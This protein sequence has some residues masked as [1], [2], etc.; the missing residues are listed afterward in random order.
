MLGEKID[1]TLKIENREISLKLNMKSLKNLGEL[2]RRNPFKY[3][4]DF[5][6]EKDEDN[7]NKMLVNILL[8]FTDANLTVEDL[9]KILDQNKEMDYL[10]SML[11]INEIMCEIEEDKKGNSKNEID[12]EEE[13]E[14]K[15]YKNWC[16]T[17]N[18]YYYIATVQF[19]MS[20]EEFL[21]TTLRELKTLDKLNKDYLKNIII[22][23]YID[24]NTARNNSGKKEVETLKAT[25]QNKVRIK[26]L[27][28]Q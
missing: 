22:S 20:K 21:D 1:L 16:D 23:Y 10:I 26:N 14:D 17:Y 18:Y 5:I 11:M 6:H 27:L 2:T 25:K 15:R 13:N 12:D 4:Y 9:P 19:H 3:L 7:K 8:A 28:M 24:V